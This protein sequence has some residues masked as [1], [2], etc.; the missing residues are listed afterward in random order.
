MNYQSTK[1]KDAVSSNGMAATSH[2][3]ATEEAIKILQKGGNAVDAAIAASFVLS[4]VEPNATSIG[5]DCFAIVKME[6]KNPVAYNGS[7]IAPGKASYDYFKKNKIDKI[8]LTSPHSVTIPGALDAWKNIHKDFG[9][10]DFEELFLKAIDFAKNGFRVTKVVADAWSNNLSKLS[11]NK[12]SKKLL[13]NNGKSY[14]FSEIRKNIPLGETLELINKKGISEFYKGSIAEDMVNCLNELGGLHTVEDFSKQK[15]IK[16]ETISSKYNNIQ[17]HQCPPNGPGIAVLIMMKL[18]EKLEINKYKYNSIERFHLEAEVTKQAY[19]IKEENIGDP[20]FVNFDLEKIL[21]DKNINNILKNI[22]LSNCSDIG[23]L[24][25]PNHPETVYLSVVDKDLNSVSI[26]NS[27]CYAFGSGITTEKTGIVLHNRGTNFR[28]EEGHPNCIEGLKRPLHTIIPGMVL[29]N[30]NNSILSYGVMGGQYQPVG[31]VHVLNSILD[32]NM[33]PQE[34][35]SFP[36]AFHF[37]NIYKLEKG[38]SAEIKNGLNKL[39][40]NAQ[41]IDDTHGG[42]Q[43]IKIDRQKGNLIGGSD[44]RKDGYAK[45]Y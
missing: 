41:Y 29:D 1:D 45:G 27:V 26:I 39:G 15:T 25:I 10:L 33:S 32:Y 5:G 28:V 34:A 37:N 3:L 14:Q 42:G 24:N 8:G 36:R 16:S 43:A 12:N 23:D 21:S 17:I 20:D 9:K 38:V 40:H 11:E 4:V 30:N 44:P 19:K 7:G 31:Q 35:I 18:L 2:P 22:S 13:L 6:G